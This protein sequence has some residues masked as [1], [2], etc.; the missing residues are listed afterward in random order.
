MPGFTEK[1]APHMVERAKA[2]G[3][4]PQKVD[5]TERKAKEF[6]QMYDNPATNV[7][8]TFTEVFPIGLAVTLLSAGILWKT[9]M[10]DQLS[11]SPV[12]RA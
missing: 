7:A 4:S 10:A 12:I 2:S 8:L 11:E 6:K 5:E 9:R 3:A 1:Y